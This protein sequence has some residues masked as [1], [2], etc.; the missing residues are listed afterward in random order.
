MTDFAPYVPREWTSAGLRTAGYQGFLP[1]A[2]LSRMSVPTQPGI[3]V[4][5]RQRMAPVEFLQESVAGHFKGRDQ[6][7]DLALLGINWIED[8]EV[9]YIGKAAWGKKRDGISRRLRQYRSIGEGRRSAHTGG[10]WIW[11]L[12]DSA[13]LLVCWIPTTDTSDAFVRGVEAHIIAD[14][15]SRYGRRP[16]ANRRD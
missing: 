16:F 9:V 8:A 12:A 7:A 4:V 3:Y 11:Q 5:L 13:D 10:V 2:A 15:V 1:F 6:T 14:F